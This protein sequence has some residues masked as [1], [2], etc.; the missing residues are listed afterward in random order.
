MLLHRHHELPRA[1]S[2]ILVVDDFPV[3]KKTVVPYTRRGN[4]SKY[5]IFIHGIFGSRG[6][7]DAML[8]PP[9][10]W[11]FIAIDRPGHGSS[12]SIDRPENFEHTVLSDA[13]LVRVFCETYG[14]QKAYFFGMSYGGSVALML[15]I[16]FPKLVAGC[17]I[18][19]AQENG[20]E[21]IRHS[22]GIRIFASLLLKNRRSFALKALSHYYA[23][24]CAQTKES[25]ESL[26]L[27]YGLMMNPHEYGLLRA[28]P[29]LTRQCSFNIRHTNKAVAAENLVSVMEL[30]LSSGLN[31]KAPCMVI[32]GENTHPALKSAERIH[33]LLPD[34]VPKKL[35]LLPDMGHLASLFAPEE[36]KRKVIQFFETHKT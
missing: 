23:R 9:P 4:G 26:K 27:F 6:D 33:A 2:E 30:K 3:G 19:G 7:F 32:D 24:R 1:V 15:A 16:L 21:L 18:Q 31:I 22:N 10:Q 8:T 34:Q 35:C 25:A 11:T 20:A 28:L 13:E 29:N 36:I 5:L 17:A 14:I 12:P